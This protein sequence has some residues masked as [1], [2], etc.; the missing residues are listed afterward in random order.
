MAAQ[1]FG[2]HGTHGGSDDEVGVQVGDLL[3]EERHGL[4]W[5]DGNVRGHDL[6]AVGIEGVAHAGGS[7]GGTAAGESVQV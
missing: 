7:A 4:G 2:V 6:N 3:A 1:L 5:H